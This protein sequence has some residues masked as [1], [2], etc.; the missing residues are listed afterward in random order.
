MAYFPSSSS[1]TSGN[2]PLLVRCL[3]KLV[4]NLQEPHRQPHQRASNVAEALAALYPSGNRSAAALP[5]A[6]VPS[7]SETGSNISGHQSRPPGFA[8]RIPGGGNKQR[9]KKQKVGGIFYEDIQSEKESRTFPKD[10]ILLQSEKTTKVPCG[11]I[12]T[13]LSENGFVAFGV[14]L[15]LSMTP[16]EVIN[17]I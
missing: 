5:E 12:R 17:I 13:N 4:Q 3:N 14:E 11:K 7:T 1:I 2:N 8:T 16:N 6:A 9:K 15:H 10:V